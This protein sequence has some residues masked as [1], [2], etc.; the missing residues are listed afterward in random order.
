MRQTGNRRDA[1]SD[2]LAKSKVMD[3]IVNLSEHSP[4]ALTFSA[5]S[6]DDVARCSLKFRGMTS[7]A[8][9][10]RSIETTH[11]RLRKRLRK[12]L[13]SDKAVGAQ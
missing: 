3:G 7:R 10:P 9:I 2:R 5:L 8:S 1:R 13:L 12:R 6:G 4:L 11:K